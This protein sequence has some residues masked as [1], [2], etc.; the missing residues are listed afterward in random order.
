MVKFVTIITHLLFRK[1]KKNFDYVS[2]KVF[3]QNGIK[4]IENFPFLVDKLFKVAGRNFQA[5]FLNL[6]KVDLFF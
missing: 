5:I 1:N 2:A 6:Y 4:N 3:L